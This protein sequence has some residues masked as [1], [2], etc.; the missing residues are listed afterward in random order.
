MLFRYAQAGDLR[1]LLGQASH[2]SLGLTPRPS[3]RPQLLG[4]VLDFV[5]LNPVPTVQGQP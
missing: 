2:N 1:T 4:P 5:A 3:P